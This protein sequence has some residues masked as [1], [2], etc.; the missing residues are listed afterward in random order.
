MKYKDIIGTDMA[1]SDAAQPVTEVNLFAVA[2]TEYVVEP[3]SNI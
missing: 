3:T 2:S 1:K